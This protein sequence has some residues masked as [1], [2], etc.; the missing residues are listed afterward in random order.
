[1][2]KPLFIPRLNDDDKDADGTLPVE[3][4]PNDDP[5]TEDEEVAIALVCGGDWFM[6]DHEI[7]DVV[8][9]WGIVI[10]PT[11]EKPFD[12]DGVADD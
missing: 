12:T 4:G 5:K 11:L 10:M 8:D 3:E 6:P 2:F 7:P 1:M 9:L